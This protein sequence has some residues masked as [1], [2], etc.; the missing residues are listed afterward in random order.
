MLHVQSMSRSAIRLATVGFVS[1]ALCLS[2]AWAKEKYDQ[3]HD[4][5]E[6]VHEG[7][8]SP[9]RQTQTE[10][11]KDAP[12]WEVIDKQLP[13][14]K[15]MSEALSKSSHDEIKDLADGYADA[16]KALGAAAQK[17]DRA[18]SQAAMKLLTN[19]CADCHFK[20]GPGGVLEKEHEQ[21]HKHKK[22]HQKRERD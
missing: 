21:E 17:R 19:S 12:A 1:R 13:A 4:Q 8:K 2:A 10:L 22:E 11:A 18:E 9:M 5:M 7:R 6:K 3:I 14:F 16:V 20:G 15:S